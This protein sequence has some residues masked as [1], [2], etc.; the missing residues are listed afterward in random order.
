MH[1]LG[2][3]ILSL[4]PS[5]TS[6]SHSL[7][8]SIRVSSCKELGAIVV[9]NDGETVKQSSALVQPRQRRS[10]GNR[11]GEEIGWG[12]K[13]GGFRNRVVSQYVG[14]NMCVVQN[15]CSRIWFRNCVVMRVCGYGSMIPNVCITRC[16]H[17][18]CCKR[19]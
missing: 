7:T 19:V 9:A 14:Q 1:C 8:E 17:G 3:L 4:P 18:V 15:M 2:V 12:Q 11:V 5:L 10:V 16:T 6:S 13:Y